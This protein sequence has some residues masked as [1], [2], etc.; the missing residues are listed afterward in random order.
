MGEA[1]DLTEKI[2]WIF[3]FLALYWAYCIAWGLR[4]SQQGASAAQYFVANR[5]LPAWVFVLGATAVSFSAW[6]F[7]GHPGLIYQDGFSY[8]FISLCAIT[9]PLAGVFLMKRQWM[10]SKRFGYF[11]QGE[12]LGDYFQGTGIRWLVS[13]IALVFAVPFVGLQLQ[14]AGFL[15]S[16]LSEG[17]I[18]QTLA[19][20]VLSVPLVIYISLGGLRSVAFVATLQSL[21]LGAGILTLGIAAYIHIGGFNSLTQALG[22]LAMSDFI[23]Q[24]ER[25]DTLNAYTAIHGV[26]EFTAGLGSEPPN[27]GIWTA[28]MILSLLLALMGAQL[29][30]TLS[31][32]A[33]ASRSPQGFGIQQVVIAGGIVGFLLIFFS[34]A[35]GVGAHFLGM[36]PEVN[37][38]GINLS[39]V[40][41]ESGHDKE[42]PLVPL[43]IRLLG[44]SAPWFVGLLGVCGIAAL[45]AASAAHLNAGASTLTRDI[46]LRHINPSA[47]AEKQKSVAR[48]MTAT[49]MLA[50]LLLA[51]FS[52]KSLIVLGGLALAFGF[53]LLPALTAACWFPWIT[54]Q[55]ATTGLVLGLF[56]VIMTENLGVASTAFFGLDLPWGRWPWT[57]HSAVWGMFFNLSACIVISGLSH[58]AEDR[59]WRQKFHDFLSEHSYLPRDKAPLRPIAWSA[60]LLWLFFAAGPGAVIGN[61]F[62]GK[63]INS[64]D[65]W[66]FG[67]PSIWAWQIMGWAL[68]VLLLWFLAYRLELSANT[69][70]R[71]EP[72][73]DDAAQSRLHAP[74]NKRSIS[75]P[76]W[77]WSFLAGGVLIVLGKWIFGS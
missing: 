46:Y 40:L 25:G 27:G 66:D 28:L 49:L 77:Y 11:T 19:T 45:Q 60:A 24:G 18:D 22:E 64:A 2:L 42:L 17:A 53:Q 71:F 12:M 9:I 15:V 50:A 1:S 65:G 63:S 61:D 43:Y 14:M 70:K 69:Q 8:A 37:N 7:I 51:T 55:G 21:L 47:D 20:W 34:T 73:V 35:Q 31:A 74:R 68:G 39:N 44:D 75:E 10:L 48:T 32:W 67:I 33:F 30:P 6:I 5:Q 13:C 36:T 72:L 57:I 23:A 56:A 59:A 54:R 38:A 62:F 58:N 26:V 76:K 52:V 29:S 4:T 41:P 16:F 3:T